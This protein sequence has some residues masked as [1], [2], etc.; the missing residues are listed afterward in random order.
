MIAPVIL[1]LICVW[2]DWRTALVL[3]A[4]VPLIPVS[5]VAVSKYAKKIFA[6]Y[7][8]KYTSMGDIFLDSVQGLKELKIFQ[9]DAAQHVKIN[10]S[11]EEFRVIT[12]KVLVMQLASTTIMDLVAYGGAGVGMRLLFAQLRFGG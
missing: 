6:K 10:E 1:F 3:I 9:A 5:I 4:C 7:W 11:A 2:I 8:G 12:M